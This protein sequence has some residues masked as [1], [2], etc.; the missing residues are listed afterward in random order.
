MASIAVTT[1]GKYSGRQP[2]MTA[3]IASSSIVAMPCRGGM[4]PNSWSGSR[5]LH[6]SMAS[7]RACVGATVVNGDADSFSIRPGV[8]ARVCGRHHRQTI[9]P[10]AGLEFVID[11]GG[12][13]GDRVSHGQAWKRN[14]GMR[15]RLPDL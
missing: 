8:D 15:R 12:V 9:G 5:S 10:A 3:F 2:A 6:A 4:S 14:P 13:E 1:T 11:G 7:T